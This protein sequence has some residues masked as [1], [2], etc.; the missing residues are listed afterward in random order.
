LGETEYR[1]TLRTD[2][3]DHVLDFAVEYTHK[4]GGGGRMKVVSPELI[5]GIEAEIGQD[6]VSLLYDGL[7]LE[8]GALPGTGLSPME[9]LPFII[10]QW[11]GGYVTQTGSEKSAGRSL[12]TVMTRRTQAEAALEVRTRFDAE[13]LAPVDAELFINGVLSVTALFEE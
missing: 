1:V 10:S 11:S 6:G 2:F 12:L 9:S 4:R 5:A 3:G 13:T 8:L 7:M